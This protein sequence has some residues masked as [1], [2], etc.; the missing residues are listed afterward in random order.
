MLSETRLFKLCAMVVATF[1]LLLS[2]AAGLIAGMMFAP[3]NFTVA[4]YIFDTAFVL[5]GIVAFTLA[6]YRRFTLSLLLAIMQFS[7][8]LIANLIR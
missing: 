3:E 2:L 8:L 7:A 6:I 5:S 1:A 4:M